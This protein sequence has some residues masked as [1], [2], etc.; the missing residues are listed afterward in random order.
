MRYLVYWKPD[1]LKDQA[2]YTG[3]A[4]EKG[5]EKPFKGESTKCQFVLPGTVCWDWMI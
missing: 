2:L 1:F 4:S 5:N 3:I